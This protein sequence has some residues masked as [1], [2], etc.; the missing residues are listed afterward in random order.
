MGVTGIFLYFFLF[1]HMLGNFG[2]FSGA[3]QYNKYGH[4]LLHDLGEILLPIEAALF[5]ALIIH[6][7]LA[8]RLTIENRAA[9]PIAYAVSP[10][11]G[12]K[13]LYSVTMMI[14]G[15]SILIF[16]FVHIAH[17]RFGAVT[18]RSMVTYNGVEMR[19]LYGTMM[20]AFAIWWYTLSYV[21][22]MLLIFSHLAHGVQSSL[23]TLGLNHPKYT[24]TLKL[25]GRTYAVFISGGFSLFAIWAYFQ[26]GG[27]P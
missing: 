6:V 11:H 4:L 7:I 15:L 14:T 21:T 12:K 18:G 24:P 20:G 9:R 10:S 19:D 8:I 5:T 16:A 22:V 23:Q 26:H 3:E 25:L 27:T 2:V 1:I 17:F 13:T